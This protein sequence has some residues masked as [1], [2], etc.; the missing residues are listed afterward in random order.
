MKIEN[1]MKDSYLDIVDEIIM[2]AYTEGFCIVDLDT[3]RIY[4]VKNSLCEY[5]KSDALGRFYLNEKGVEYAMSGCS[6]GIKDRIRRQEELEL[7]EIETKKFTKKKQAWTFRISIVSLILSALS[8]LGQLGFLSLMLQW[9]S[10]KV[11][12]ICNLWQ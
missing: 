11:Q 7:L 5:G 4:A 6:K 10:T 12:W 9:I 3:W 2:K 8:I 1:N